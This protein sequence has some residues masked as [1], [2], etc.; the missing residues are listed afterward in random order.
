MSQYFVMQVVHYVMA[1]N[2]YQVFDNYKLAYLL[3]V[4]VF[5]RKEFLKY[6]N[7]Y[8]KRK[9]TFMTNITSRFVFHDLQS[10]AI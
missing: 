10:V 1:A 3:Y 9:L 8:R 6:G 2:F 5:Q 7:R 4:K